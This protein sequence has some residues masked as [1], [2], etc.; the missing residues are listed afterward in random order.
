MQT[1]ARATIVVLL[2][3]LAT[4]AHGQFGGG[5]APAK[6]ASSPAST[7]PTVTPPGAPTPPP[8][9]A[10]VVVDDEEDPD[11]PAPRPK[12]PPATAPPTPELPPQRI[13]CAQ[14][15]A[16]WMAKL[17]SADR[18]AIEAGLGYSLARIS[19]DLKWVGA[20]AKDGAPQLA[21]K[22]IV[23]QFFDVAS[24]GTGVLDK[25]IASLGALAADGSVIVV[26]V[27][28][29]SKVDAATKRLEKSKCKANICVDERGEFCDAMGAFKK[30]VNVI[31][32]RNGA[33]RFVGLTEKGTAL[34]AKV[35]LAEPVSEVKAAAKPVAVVVDTAGVQFPTFTE[36]LQYS[37]DLRGQKS[38]DLSVER[39]ITQQ[40]KMFG[41]VVVVDF[42][43]TWCGPC[44]AARKHMNEL[45]RAYSKDVVVV[46]LSTET[47]NKFT[48]G[49]KKLHLKENDFDYSI[50]LDPA[51]RM[52][53]AF[54]VRGIPSI[55]IISSD[56]IVR[57]QGSP[58][59]LTP[60]VL[61]SIIAANAKLAGVGKP[62]KNARGWAK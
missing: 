40:P 16:S 49:L 41:K 25:T 24:G 47:N 29:P 14:P 52:Q 3:G 50:A 59:G 32:D 22:I 6:P 42:F 33:V 21:G 55:A 11:A 43:A 54:G 2:G 61:D 57:W 53:S 58:Q 36:P 35:L 4:G 26:G 31:V 1:L 15:E 18:D 20:T 27:Q 30:P 28:V 17:E 34:A 13:T 12:A 5:F 60:A 45:A 51:A 44:M 38:P 19:S 10:P 48:D 39:W 56:Q 37:A 7:P 8:Q 9:Q 23:I 46:G 62:D